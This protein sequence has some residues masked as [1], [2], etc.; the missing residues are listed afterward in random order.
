MQP[1][2]KNKIKFVQIYYAPHS[3]W[4]GQR[5]HPGNATGKNSTQICRT[6]PNR[7][8]SNAKLGID[9][10]TESLSLILLKT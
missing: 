9:T 4:V 7:D 8:V 6:S 2:K 5:V 3:L 10:K 1:Q